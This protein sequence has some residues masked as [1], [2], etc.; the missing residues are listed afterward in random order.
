MFE[1]NTD[2]FSAETIRR[3]ASQFEHLLTVIV[4]RPTARLSELDMLTTAERSQMVVT[5]NRTLA[6]YSDTACVHDLIT[7]QTRRSPD[8]VA[9]EFQDQRLTYAELD[10]DPVG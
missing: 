3:M 9:V 5:W 2:L 4:D 1:Y 6:P 8:R 7:A 10:C